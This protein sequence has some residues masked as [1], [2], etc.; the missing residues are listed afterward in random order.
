MP[1]VADAVHCNVPLIIRLDAYVRQRGGILEFTVAGLRT[2]FD[3][4]ACANICLLGLLKG[5]GLMRLL[6][7]CDH[8]S[9]SH[10][11]AI[12]KKEQGKGRIVHDRESQMRADV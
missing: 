8:E 4:R 10:F 7:S 12:S 2:N 1:D 6:R 11:G 9:F 5:T 3:A